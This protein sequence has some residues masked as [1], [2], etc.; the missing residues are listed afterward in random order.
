MESSMNFDDRLGK[1]RSELSPLRA[2]LLQHLI[3]GEIDSLGN[4]HLFMQHHVFAVWDFMSLLKALQQR[5]CGSRVPWLP[6]DGRT[7]A[8]LVNEIVLAEESDD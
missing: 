5:L 2:S 7:A 8:R 1:I 4:L 6:S 3:Y